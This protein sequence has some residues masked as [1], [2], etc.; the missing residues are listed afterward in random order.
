MKNKTKIIFKCVLRN[1]K[2]PEHYWG[3]W[4]NTKPWTWGE[5]SSRYQWRKCERC[6]YIE[7]TNLGDDC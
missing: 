5:C 7:E 3:K 4:D 1:D 2:Q 6:G